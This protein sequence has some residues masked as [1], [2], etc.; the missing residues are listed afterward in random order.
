M[1][2]KQYGPESEEVRLSRGSLLSVRTRF[3]GQ[4]GPPHQFRPVTALRVLVLS[5]GGVTSALAA[6]PTGFHRAPG[7]GRPS[8]AHPRPLRGCAEEGADPQRVRRLEAGGGG[9]GR[10]RPIGC[11]RH[12]QIRLLCLQQMR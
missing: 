2:G 6:S 7:T 9:R 5:V 3:L 1:D 4:P 8:D 12:G 10:R 11:I